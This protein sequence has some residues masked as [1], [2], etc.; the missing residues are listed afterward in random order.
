MLRSLVNEPLRSSARQ[1]AR[2]D[3]RATGAQAVTV[4]MGTGMGIRMGTGTGMGT[5]GHRREV[6]APP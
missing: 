5:P 6:S 3:L 4:G 2:G 1:R